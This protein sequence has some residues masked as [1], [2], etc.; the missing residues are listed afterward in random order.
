MWNKQVSK[1]VR[2]VTAPECDV[3]I[4]SIKILSNVSYS[5]NDMVSYRR[6]LQQA[7]W[8]AQISRT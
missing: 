6:R 8:E 7:L 4:D 5:P 1:Y 2:D 3:F